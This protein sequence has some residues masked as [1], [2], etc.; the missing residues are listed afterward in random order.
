M[1][2][3]I[4]LAEAI[5]YVNSVGPRGFETFGKG[6]YDPDGNWSV[7]LD[8]DPEN[9][10]N[11]D[12]AVLE[13]VRSKGQSV[14]LAYAAAWPRGGTPYAWRYKIGDYYRAYRAALKALE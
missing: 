13:G 5:G 7:T 11:D 10:A 2:D 9:D 14:L 12:Y 8:F 1:N 4:K 6:W 3:K